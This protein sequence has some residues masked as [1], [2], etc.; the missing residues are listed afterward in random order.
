VLFSDNVNQ[1]QTL[2]MSPLDYFKAVGE[3]VR[4]DFAGPHVVGAIQQLGRWLSGASELLVLIPLH[5]AA[6]ATLVRVGVFGWRFDPWLRIVAL[7]A[8]LQHGIGICYVNAARYNLGTWLL[9]ALVAAAWLHGEGLPLCD[10]IKPGLRGRWARAAWLQWLGHGV[11]K[12]ERMLGPS[13]V[14]GKPAAP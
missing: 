11:Q 4:L 2:L 1:P 8:L 3:I 10:R 7:A 12:I 14:D 13:T 6:V 9:T 5:A